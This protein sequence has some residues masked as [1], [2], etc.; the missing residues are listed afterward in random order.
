[1]LFYKDSLTTHVKGFIQ[2]IYQGTVNNNPGKAVESCLFDVIKIRKI[3]GME[4]EVG[5]ETPE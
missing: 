3:G 5:K 1:M 2:I 4:G